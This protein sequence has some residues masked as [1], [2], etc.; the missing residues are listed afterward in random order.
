[1]LLQVGAL[2]AGIRAA[3]YVI[4]RVLLPLK[5]IKRDG[6]TT[7]VERTILVTAEEDQRLNDGPW[8]AVLRAGA[9]RAADYAAVKGDA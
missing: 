8:G 9:Q 2:Y 5:G 1:M 4:E 3:T 6:S 7:F